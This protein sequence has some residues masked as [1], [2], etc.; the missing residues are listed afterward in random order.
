MD[1]FEEVIASEDP[2]LMKKK[3]GTVQEM[4]ASIERPCENCRQEVLAS[5]A[6]ARFKDS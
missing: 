6:M 5:L 3:R 1:S 4:M 2:E